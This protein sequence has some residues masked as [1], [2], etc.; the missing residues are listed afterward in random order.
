MKNFRTI[1]SLIFFIILFSCSESSINE[2]SKVQG[3]DITT[4]NGGSLS[5]ITLSGTKASYD[6]QITV[7]PSF[8][9]FK[10][11][12]IKIHLA[13]G[14]SP[15]YVSFDIKNAKDN[16]ITFT[17][18]DDGT[19]TGEEPYK[20]SVVAEHTPTG[21]RSKEFIITTVA[22]K[23]QSGFTISLG[24]TPDKLQV[25]ESGK[26]TIVV[27]PVST[28]LKKEN[29]SLLTENNMA[30]KY[31]VLEFASSDKGIYTFNIVDKRSIYEEYK[32]TL[33]IVYKDGETV[34]TQTFS[35]ASAPEQKLKISKVFIKL[36]DGY[37]RAKD[38]DA[39]TTS[40]YGYS[41]NGSN[42]E[43][44]Y[45]I[46]NRT[47]IGA[48]ISIEGAEGLDNL[49]SMTTKIK[50]RGNLTWSW[51]KKPYN[52]KLDSR[53]KI[54][55]MNPHKR[56]CLLANTID[57]THMRN[58]LAYHVSQ[59]MSFDYAVHSQFVE[60]YFTNS[61]GTQDYRGL[62][63]LT[64]NIKEDKE[65]RVPLTEVKASKTGVAGDKIGY[66]LEFDMYYDEAGR[67]LTSPSRLP[68]NIK[69]PAKDDWDDA[70][71]TAQYETYRNYISSYVS[72]VDRLICNLTAGG[73]STAIW[74]KLDIESM[75]NF[76]IVFEVM[77]CREILWPKSIYFHKEV[78]EKLKAGPTWDFDY[79]TLNASD[80][81]TWINHVN[82]NVANTN[83]Q[84]WSG[85]SGRTWWAQL[86]EK[87][88]TFRAEIKKQWST[89]YPK[90]Q[91]IQATD[92]DKI[93]TLLKEADERNA[94]LWKQ[95]SVSDNPN[96]DKT[97][98][99]DNAVSTLKSTFNT[100]INW[101]NSQINAM[102]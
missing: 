20:Y 62:Y 96:T 94:N 8:A 14:G 19:F 99:F 70:G 61:N 85:K 43:N 29:F 11:N 80:A 74:E 75:A 92:F 39:K 38:L 41:D 46:D 12:D 5:S 26:L 77:S 54:L 13:S 48:T 28:V 3:L 35:I 68:V 97:Y 84:Y 25:G 59:Q 49:E 65:S 95:S 40:L 64:E 45:R 82:A 86:I 87:D 23:Q 30:S 50:G 10:A 1:L 71:N 60:L 24:S 81:S 27:N 34:E 73:N 47:W 22:Q 52:L 21:V 76:W 83:T 72:E 33:K 57:R 79:R 53:S 78:G 4:V 17:V 15:Q 31:L 98:T 91:A 69:Y 56:W 102:K 18:T 66:L 51:S 88:P 36:D 93:K 63:L 9:T 89:V 101:L 32:E 58:W 7:R 42:F 37:T 100:R 44:Q 67:F 2:D 90:L 6:F 16:V 55:G